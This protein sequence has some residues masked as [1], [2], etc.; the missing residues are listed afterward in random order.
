MNVCD[1]CGNLV[2]PTRPDETDP[3]TR[4]LIGDWIHVDSETYACPVP[5]RQVGWDATVD[6][7]LDVQTYRLQNA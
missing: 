2:R 6:G 7:T 4:S 1:H 5:N 3:D